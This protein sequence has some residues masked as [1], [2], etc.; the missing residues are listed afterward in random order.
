MGYCDAQCPH[1]LK[2]INGEANVDQWVPADVDVNAGKGEHG[3]CCTEID[4]WEANKISTAFTMHSCAVEE[5]TRCEGV[6]CGDK[7]HPTYDVGA[8]ERFNGVCDKNG[9]NIQAHRFGT[10]DFWGPGAKFTI[11]STK[12]VAVT[13]QF[14]HNRLYRSLGILRY[15]RL[16]SEK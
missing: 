13:T 7:G 6:G 2:W 16:F 10:T 1:D 15:Q 11:D 8:L 4:I 3:S 12:P 5:Q 14:H 9:C